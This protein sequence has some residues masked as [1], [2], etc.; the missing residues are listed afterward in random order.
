MSFHGKDY[1]VLYDNGHRE[2][3]SAKEVARMVLPHELEQVR[4][5]SRVAVLWGDREYY[6]ATVTQERNKKRPLYLEYDGGDT[7]WVDLRHLKF[8][9]IY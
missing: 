8:R 2:D 9:R 1:Q 6:E 5:G 7:E 3:Y 4:V